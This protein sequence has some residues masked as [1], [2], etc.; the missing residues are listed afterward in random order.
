[1]HVLARRTYEPG[2]ARELN[3]FLLKKEHLKWSGTG[4]SISLCAPVA[5]M[6]A[7][8]EDNT[9]GRTEDVEEQVP[10]MFAAG[11]CWCG[12]LG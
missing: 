9:E 6:S 12:G 8:D 7:A 11:R 4:Q 5:P 3:F 1:M 2:R 10:T